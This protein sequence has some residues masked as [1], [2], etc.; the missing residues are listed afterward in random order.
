M[1]L[2]VAFGN[3]FSHC[4]F[5]K[6]INI[7]TLHLEGGGARQLQILRNIYISKF[8]TTLT[9]INLIAD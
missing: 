1:K 5:T 9:K 4:D 3:T 6:R 2:Q 7:D 8:N